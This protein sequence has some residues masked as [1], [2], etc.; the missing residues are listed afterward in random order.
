MCSLGREKHT[1]GHA[2]SK[3]PSARFV[4]R[5]T[6]ASLQLQGIQPCK[7]EIYVGKPAFCGN[8]QKWGHRVWQCDGRT[9]RGFC[10]GNHDTRACKEKIEKG[11]R[12][13]PRCPNCYQEHNAW[14]VRCPLRPDS[15]HSRELIRNQAAVPEPDSL[16]RRIP[17]STP[18]DPTAADLTGITSAEISTCHTDL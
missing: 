2:S 15:Y 4:E 11:E 5:R 12:I 9:R 1:Q 8:C 3:E 16:D 10:S 7:V 18:E 17:T 14:S 6:T 13:T